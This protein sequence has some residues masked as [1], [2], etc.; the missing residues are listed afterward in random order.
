MVIQHNIAAI[1]AQRQIKINTDNRKKSTEKLSSGY[2]IN[3]AADDAAGLAISEKMRR[4]I[5]GLTQNMDN[6][7]DGISL[8]QVADGYLN[9]VHD[10]VQRINELAVKGANDTLTD[11]DRSYIDSEVQQIKNEIDRIFH[12][13]TFNEIPIFNTPYI[14]SVGGSPEPY[15]MQIFYSNDGSL[16][17][18]EF[19][20]VRYNI[21]ELN[22]KGLDLDATGIANS[23][24][25]A[26]FK[27]WDGENVHLKLNKG[28][29][30]EKVQRIYNWNANE[31]GIYVNEVLATTWADMGISGA[32][33]A[34]TYDFKFHGM[35]ISFYVE[36]GDDRSDIIKGIRGEGLLEPTY[37]T[38]S[39]SSQTSRNIVSYPA[40][41]KVYATNSNKN[42]FMDDYVISADTTGISVTNTTTGTST[43]VTPWSSFSHQGPHLESDTHNTNYPIVDWGIDNDSNGQSDTTFDTEA[44]Y[45]Y[46]SPDSSLAVGFDFQL[47]DVSSQSQVIDAMNNTKLDGEIHNSGYFSTSPSDGS[48]LSITN[49]NI[50]MDGKDS[51]IMQK[52]YGRNFDGSAAMTG[53]ITWTKTYVDGSETDHSSPIS[54]LTSTVSSS[55]N[56]T[57]ADYYYHDTATDTYYKYTQATTVTNLNMRTDDKYRW[58]KDYEVQYSGSLGNSTMQQTAAEPVRLRYDKDTVTTFTRTNTEYEYTNATALTAEEVADLTAAGTS[59]NEA[60]NSNTSADSG[61]SSSSNTYLSNGGNTLSHTQQYMDENYTVGSAFTFNHS[62]SYSNLDSA[63][64]GS[65]SINLNFDG[66]AYR[67]L[68]PQP[69]YKMIS[70]HDFNNIVVVPPVKGIVIQASPNEAD[71]QQ[72][73][74]QWSPMNLGVIGLSGTNTLTTSAALS[75]ITQAKTALDAVSKERST[76]GSYQNSLEH[77]YN[78]VANTRENVQASETRIRDTEMASESSRLATH[79]LLMESGQMVLAQA[80]QTKQ[81]VMTL[82]Q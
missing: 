12:V 9:E 25:D 31:T 62:I 41:N 19:N 54:S 53:N 35:E 26:E 56:T 18:L 17:G 45:R 80:N 43:S 57:Y 77:A 61:H 46:D 10:M 36:E 49:A 39:V 16:G 79:N 3:R 22:S 52:E 51:F 60:F 40:S 37:W 71:V 81:G 44:V 55:S 58:T 30:L 38:T 74:M 32:V 24:I 29:T 6:I 28:D 50:A 15:D 65:V 4:E 78:N 5:R 33:T 7:Q 1:S 34:G 70:E 27:L 14:P 48:S 11:Q 59:F 47:A 63:A 67:E 82:L 42:A 64:T 72:I 20:N 21:S 69:A 76:F 75:A 13:A 8:C 2:R 23:D 68:A 73:I 66:R